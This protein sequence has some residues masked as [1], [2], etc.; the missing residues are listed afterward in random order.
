M[1]RGAWISTVSVRTTRQL[2]LDVDVQPRSTEEA[3]AATAIRR[4]R[5]RK[6]AQVQAQ[7]QVQVQRNTAA[8]GERSSKRLRQTTVESFFRPTK[9]AS[10]ES[11]ESKVCVAGAAPNQSV[12]VAAPPSPSPPPPAPAP[13]ASNGDDQASS[14][15]NSDSEP[16]LP[17]QEDSEGG[18]D[19]MQLPP[20]SLPQSPL[21]PNAT[22][23]ADIA[24]P[25]QPQRH[26][27]SPRTPRSSSSPLSHRRTSSQAAGVAALSQTSVDH[28]L[29]AAADVGDFSLRD[30]SGVSLSSGLPSSQEQRVIATVVDAAAADDSSNDS[31]GDDEAII[32]VEGDGVGAADAAVEDE[33][34]NHSHV[35]DGAEVLEME[36]EEADGEANGKSCGNDEE[37]DPNTPNDAEVDYDAFEEDA[38]YVAQKKALAILLLASAPASLVEDEDVDRLCGKE[39]DDNDSSD[40]ARADPDPDAAENGNSPIP[41]MPHSLPSH[42]PEASA[43]SSIAQSSIADEIPYASFSLPPAAESCDKSVAESESLLPPPPSTPSPQPSPSIVRSSARRSL[44]TTPTRKAEE[45]GT[46]A[47]ASVTLASRTPS[48]TIRPAHPRRALAICHQSLD[49]LF[50]TSDHHD[51]L[52]KSPPQQQQQPRAQ[53]PLVFDQSQDLLDEE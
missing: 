36:D 44:S 42:A 24:S 22:G 31:G 1:E 41:S 33:C 27:Q 52:I 4:Q 25:L 47:G 14:E 32:P 5:Q 46:T 3:A 48:S 12:T 6:Q 8:D 49:L 16:L 28:L 40:H 20:Q 30:F 19:A 15:P 2:E 34:S 10:K 53:P 35:A 21:Q 26:W 17:S 9:S 11:G 23:I 7:M 51:G 37:P 29:A 50:D 43:Q 13:P 18:T 39:V 38:H 45:T